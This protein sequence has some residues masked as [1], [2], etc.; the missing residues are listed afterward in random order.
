M[1]QKLKKCVKQPIFKYFITFQL[2][3]SIFV[4]TINDVF[5]IGIKNV[6]F[7]FYTVIRH[8]RAPVNALRPDNVLVA[9][10][11]FVDYHCIKH[12]KSFV[13]PISNMFDF[14]D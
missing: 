12:L 4:D 9:D 5:R 2:P 14:S 7:V 11:H 3:F 8:K 10:P 13:I 6:F 1:T